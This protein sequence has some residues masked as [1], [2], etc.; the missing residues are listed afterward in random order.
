MTKK[1]QKYIEDK[2]ALIRAIV[3]GSL[4]GAYMFPPKNGDW[5]DS[6]NYQLEKAMKIIEKDVIKIYKQ[7]KKTGR[8][9]H[10]KPPSP[11][12]G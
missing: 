4:W 2:L 1:E 7:G 5:G 9:T 8:L 11:P 3:L 6:A 12:Q 10:P